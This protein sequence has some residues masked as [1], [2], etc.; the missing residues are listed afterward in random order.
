MRYNARLNSVLPLARDDTFA[1]DIVQCPAPQT[2]SLR[3][4][5]NLEMRVAQ[6][7]YPPTNPRF[8]YFNDHTE[9]ILYSPTFVLSNIPFLDEK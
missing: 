4:Q 6:M 9:V 5:K 7:F 3:S 2:E 8:P 1:F